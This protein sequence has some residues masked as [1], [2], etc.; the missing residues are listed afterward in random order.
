MFY[1]YK[2]NATVYN[3][4]NQALDYNAF[5]SQG[6][7]KDFSNVQTLDQTTPNLLSSAAPAP[8]GSS[9]PVATPSVPAGLQMP[10]QPNQQP[11]QP[12]QN[13]QQPTPIAPNTPVAPAPT[14]PAA[15][16]TTPTPVPTSPAAPTFSPNGVVGTQSIQGPDFSQLIGQRQVS[17]QDQIEYFDAQSGQGFSDPKQLADFVNKQAGGQVTDEQGVFDY[18]DQQQQQREQQQEQQFQESSN[19]LSDNGI[20]S[21]ALMETAK[22]QNPLI[23]FADTYSQM[24]EKMGIP[25]VKE[26]L[27]KINKQYG[28]LQNELNDKISAVNDNP[29]LTE[30]VRV[31]E[32][33]KLEDKYEGKLKILTGQISQ[34]EKLY[35]D[36]TDQAK[37]VAQEAV[38]MAHD[39][40]VLDQAL[41]IQKMSLAEKALEYQQSQDQRNFEFAQTQ[42][43]KNIP[44]S[45][46]EYQ[47]AKQDGFQGSYNDYQTMDANRKAVRSTTVNNM[48]GDSGLNSKQVTVLNGIVDKY[49]KSPLVQASDRTIVLKNTIDQIKKNP[50]NAALQLN[51]AYSYIQALD[52]YQSAVREG[53]LSLVN[54]IDSKVGQLSNYVS[55]MT[56]GQIVRPEVALQIA[57]AATNLVSTI[58][59]AA[60]AKAKSFQSQAQVSG[61]GDAFSSY[62]SGFQPSYSP[63]QSSSNVNLQAL[64]FKF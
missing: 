56:N 11:A 53:E 29:W 10:T 26:E 30:G 3:D 35:S 22:S 16:P 25:T 37:F 45:Y 51:L 28:D 31:Q 57:D 19:T 60:S 64:D 50:S 47:L 42:S 48:I 1:K 32:V 5:I 40:A 44:T 12:A 63:T 34:Y 13:P 55:Q 8:V 9:T 43:T 62:L 59:Q 7:A 24:L 36:G 17:G 21:N 4:R 14:N 49:N 20:D 58:S 46:Q 6:G 2:D 38:N 52:T 15:T 39:Q 33:R 61:V 23:T 18:L 54:S 41:L 27:T